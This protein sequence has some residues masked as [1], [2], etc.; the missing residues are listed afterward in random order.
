MSEHEQLKQWLR[1][2]SSGD[3]RQSA[4]GAN[5]IDELEDENKRL[6]E[7][8]DSL[9]LTGGTLATIVEAEQGVNDA[10]DSWYGSIDNVTTERVSRES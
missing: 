8:I 7:I 6:N 3:Y 10:C 2:H 9:V 4:M 1:D 5:V